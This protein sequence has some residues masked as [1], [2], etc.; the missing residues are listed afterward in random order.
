[1]TD[2]RLAQ[3]QLCLDTNP[4]YAL[5]LFEQLRVENIDNINA[6]LGYGVALMKLNRFEEAAA[7]LTT[8]NLDY[9]EILINAGLCFEKLNKLDDALTT[10]MKFINNPN[11]D[12][13]LYD[14]PIRKAINIAQ[15]LKRW[16]DVKNAAQRLVNICPDVFE[17]VFILGSAYKEL[18]QL[19]TAAL[20]FK[21]AA[22]LRPDMAHVCWE[23]IGG[24]YKDGGD[25][26]IATEYFRKAWN[27]NKNPGYA[28]AY[29]MTLQYQS[30]QY[31]EFLQAA[32]EFDKQFCKAP[33]ASRS[34]KTLDPEKTKTGLRIGWM[35]GDFIGHSLA[36]LLLEPFKLFKQINSNHKHYIYM[37]RE[38]ETEINNPAT[39]AYKAAVDVW[40]NIHGKS[41]IEAANQIMEDKIDILIDIAGFTA[42]H[43][44]EVFKYKPA[45]VQGGWVCG[46]MTPAG[47]S[48]I[49]YFFTDQWMRPPAAEKI[50]N[51]K[52]MI[53]P[54]AYTYFPLVKM[55][56][57]PTP[58]PAKRNGYITFGSFNNT[59]KITP[60]VFDTWLNVLNRVP[61]SRLHVKVYDTSGASAFRHKARSQGID[62]RRIVYVV[63][64]PGAEDVIN[65]YCN[66]IDI[67]LDTWPCTGCLVSAEAMWLGVPVVTLVGDTF[68]HRQTWTILNQ[69]G[70]ADLGATTTE[71][72]IDV[73]VRLAE[74]INRLE[75]LRKTLRSMMNEAP[76]RNPK[77]IAENVLKS[78]EDMWLDWCTSR[79][80]LAEGLSI[81]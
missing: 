32:S 28:S 23:M 61:T 34:L 31:G 2:E 37:A 49:N 24:C 52:L 68:L 17:D 44:L 3:A 29:I 72:Y 10:M 48:S 74:N 53:L 8:C 67:V 26:N 33:Q 59:C 9:P 25:V 39:N 69:T 5:T 16:H 75:L 22:Q 64:L 12:A 14:M 13:M 76:I 7:F 19:R 77:L 51:E 41:D 81:F 71:Q 73:A 54:A 56:E 65:Y 42:Y 50:G 38:P 70:L 79:H 40:R 80:A 46:M 45:P 1:M 35:S 21:H 30:A 63:N 36:N 62:D 58:L 27:A 43:R 60:E 18:N 55:P 4:S 15:G 11:I 20:Y 78:C 57:E 6:T 47:L 66:H